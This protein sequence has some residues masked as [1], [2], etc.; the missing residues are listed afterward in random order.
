MAS[1]ITLSL[2]DSDNNV[3][4]ILSEVELLSEFLGLM[5]AAYLCSKTSLGKSFYLLLRRATSSN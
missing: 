3:S 2:L 5:S 1:L 4:I